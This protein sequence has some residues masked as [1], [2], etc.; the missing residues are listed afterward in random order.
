MFEQAPLLEGAAWIRPLTADDAGP[1]AEAYARNREYLQ[2]WEPVRPAGFYAGA[3]QHTLVEGALSERAAGRAVHWILLVGG[4]IVGR[5][6]LTDIVRGV[7][8]NGHVGYWVD[9]QFQ[10]R[11]VAT[12]AVR[13]VCSHASTELKL[14]RLQAG[15][16]TTNAGSQ[17]V[18]SRN[19]FTPIGLAEKYL[20][21]N[22]D[23]QDHLLFQRILDSGHTP[24]P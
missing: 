13:H 20:R 1:L 10:G 24:A 11:G 4:G 18:L 6:S 12:A 5:I 17:E 21:I 16:L 15:T 9:E 8:Q 14:H 3:G 7:F 2:P 19:G 23:W 22:G